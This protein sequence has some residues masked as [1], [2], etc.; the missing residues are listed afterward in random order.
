NY[1]MG[2]KVIAA[3]L[4]FEK[5]VEYANL[6]K[7]YNAVPKYPSIERDIAILVKEEVTNSEIIDII[8]A[9]GGKNLVEVKL[10]DIYRGAQIKSDYKSVAYKMIF[11]AKNRTLTYEEVQKPY[12]KI[13][14]NLEEKLGAI[15]R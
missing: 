5:I 10:F 9:N 15:R 7:L 3:E 8:K 14:R 4:D 6:T 11:R 2:S 12:D 13:L 1:N